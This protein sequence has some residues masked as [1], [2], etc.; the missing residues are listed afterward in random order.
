T[1]VAVFGPILFRG[2]VKTML[3]PTWG[4]GSLTIFVSARSA[5]CGVSGALPLLLP[6]FGSNWSECGMVAV[7]VRAAV[8]TTVAASVS[9]CWEA[10]ARLPT[11]HTPVPGT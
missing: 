9:V 4:V 10:L 2:T 3:S 7:L 6:V 11:V 5:C 8:L 1:L